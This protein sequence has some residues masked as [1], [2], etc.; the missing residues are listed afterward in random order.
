ME[1]CCSCDRSRDTEGPAITILSFYPWTRSLLPVDGKKPHASYVVRSIICRR[2]DIAL[3]T[4]PS[5]LRRPNEAGEHI[6]ILARPFPRNPFTWVWFRPSGAFLHSREQ[7]WGSAGLH[8]GSPYQFAVSVGSCSSLVI[9]RSLRSLGR[10]GAALRKSWWARDPGLPAA[11][12]ATS[13]DAAAR[14]WQGKAGKRAGAGAWGTHPV[15]SGARGVPLLGQHD[16][17]AIFVIRC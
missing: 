7:P 13:F 10:G 2:L 14:I 12:L 5:L 1:L 3:Q 8:F 9:N 6:P 4:P 15:A 16:L 11:L 17:K